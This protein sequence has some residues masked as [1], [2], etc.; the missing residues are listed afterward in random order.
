MRVAQ[1]L[2]EQGYITYMRTDSVHLSD[3]AI[4]AARSCVEQL[5]GKQYL[6]PQPRQYT[7]K[8]KGAQEAHEAIRPAG[9]SFRTPQETGLGG[10]E[11][12]VYDLIWKRT[13]ASPNG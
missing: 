12:A 4:A 2:Y 8:S 9:S 10:R 1:N 7:T 11:F 13:V 3:Q 5:Y 6:S